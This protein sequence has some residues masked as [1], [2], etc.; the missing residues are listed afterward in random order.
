[1]D[2]DYLRPKTIPISETTLWFEFLLDPS[3][4]EKHL[5]KSSP[6]YVLVVQ[7]NSNILFNILN[8]NL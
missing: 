4:L 7:N 8:D 6:G 5:A 2:A 3:L 1:M